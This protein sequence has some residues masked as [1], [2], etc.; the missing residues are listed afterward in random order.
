M[1]NRNVCKWYDE[2]AGM[3]RA[4]DKGLLDKKWIEEYFLNEG[5]GCASPS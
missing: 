1:K 5:K 2:T 4:Y 3:K